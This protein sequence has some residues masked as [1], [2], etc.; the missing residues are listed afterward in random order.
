MCESF[1]VSFRGSFAISKLKGSRDLGR[2]YPSDPLELRV[3]E[4]GVIRAW[5][6]PEAEPGRVFVMIQLPKEQSGG[7]VAPS[8]DA[9]ASWIGPF[10]HDAKCERVRQKLARSNLSERHAF[11]VVFGFS[12]VEFSVTEPLT[13]DDPPLPQEEPSVPDEIT[14]VWIASTWN[15]GVV[16]RWSAETGWAMSPKSG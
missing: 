3:T 11:V 14:D 9:V 7:W 10:L 15:A 13:R 2:R 12:D 16:F 6:A 1:V 5:R 4:L 8:T